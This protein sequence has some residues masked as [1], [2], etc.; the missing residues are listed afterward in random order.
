MPIF[1]GRGARLAERLRGA[2]IPTELFLAAGSPCRWPPGSPGFA[3]AGHVRP[4]GF[5]VIDMLDPTIE[6][7]AKTGILSRYEGSLGK[8]GGEVGVGRHLS[9]APAH[10]HR[11]MGRRAAGGR[12]QALRMQAA[13]DKSRGFGT[14]EGRRSARE[15]S[16]WFG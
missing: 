13:D 9:P 4:R 10:G 3:P 14:G 1:I 8:R 5:P 16:G 15:G 11:H 7:P 12:G 2:G 6:K